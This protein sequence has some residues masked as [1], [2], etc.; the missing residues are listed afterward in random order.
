MRNP[1]R[2]DLTVE[3]MILRYHYICPSCRKH[4][5]LRV[6]TWHWS[7]IVYP[8]TDDHIENLSGEPDPP[9]GPDE[10][11][12]W[13]FREADDTG[14]GPYNL[15]ENSDAICLACEWEGKLDVCAKAAEEV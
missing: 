15:M 10:P 3:E 14:D 8:S 6:Q 11:D 5:R 7:D 13:Y 9:K 4:N 12:D 1:T 2:R